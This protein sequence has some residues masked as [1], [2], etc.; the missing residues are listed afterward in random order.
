MN[1]Y[2]P[3]INVGSQ[4]MVSSFSCSLIILQ[5]S[6]SDAIVLWR[7]WIMWERSMKIMILPVLLSLGLTG[8]WPVSICHHSHITLIS[9]A[10]GIC[11][12]FGGLGVGLIGVYSSTLAT[13]MIATMLMAVKAWSVCRKN[14]ILTTG[15]T[16]SQ[17]TSSPNQ[18]SPEQRGIQIPGHIYPCSP[19]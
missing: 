10:A 5:Y 4:T 3:I 1:F 13:N 16:W 2:L 14:Q 9:V 7:V 6:L 11:I 17:A 15:L 12:P 18:N 8:K 19:C